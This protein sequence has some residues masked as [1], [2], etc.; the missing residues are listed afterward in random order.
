VLI[1]DYYREDR[2]GKIDSRKQLAEKMGLPINALRIRSHRIRV[3][4]E[5]CVA[6]CLRKSGSG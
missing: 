1:L 4:L 2:G 3:Q 6:G 5:K